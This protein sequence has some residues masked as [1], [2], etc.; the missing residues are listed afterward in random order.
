MIDIEVQGI[1]CVFDEQALNDFDMLEKLSDMSNGDVTAMVGF[2]RGIFGIEQLDNIKS[3]L[4]DEDGICR[5]DAMAKFV[6]DAIVAASKAQK[7]EPK[8]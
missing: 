7:A 4:R 6:S 5:L 2:A 3:Q 8:N 1:P